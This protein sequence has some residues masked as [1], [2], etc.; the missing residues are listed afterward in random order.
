MDNNST[1]MS[2]LKYGLQMEGELHQK[3][4]QTFG[5]LKRTSHSDP[6]D[7][8]NTKFVIELS[9]VSASHSNLFIGP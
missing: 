7:Y 4:N 5:I 9:R 3:F 1:K 8:I 2:D 6:F